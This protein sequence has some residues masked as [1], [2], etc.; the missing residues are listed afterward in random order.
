MFKSEVKEAINGNIEP[1]LI[2]YDEALKSR[3]DRFETKSLDVAMKMEDIENQAEKLVPIY[4][5]EL[6]VREKVLNKKV[7]MWS[8]EELNQFEYYFANKYIRLKGVN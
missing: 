7:V 4:Q 5:A 1:V 2:S 3:V 8:E 6:I